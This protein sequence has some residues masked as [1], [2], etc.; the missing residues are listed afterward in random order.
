MFLPIGSVLF[1]WLLSILGLSSE[2]TKFFTTR[3]V[4]NEFKDVNRMVRA[5]KENII[6]RARLRL[7]VKKFM[8]NP[9]GAFI[10][11]PYLVLFISVP[12]ALI[13]DFIALASRINLSML[14]SPGA[15]FSVVHPGLPSVQTIASFDGIAV[16][17]LF[18]VV[19]PFT[20]F[21]ELRMHKIKKLDSTIP[22]FLKR[23][24]GV[25]ESGLTL[26]QAVKSLLR[27]NLGVLN[28]EVKKMVR[29]MEWG[30]DIKDALVRFE[31]RVSTPSISRTVTLITEASESSG[32]IKETLEIAS[33]DAGSAQT[34]QEE[35]STNML[36]YVLIVYIS[37]FV[38][39][40]IIY[41]LVV[42]FMPALPG[43]S[44]D[45]SMQSMSTM[46]ISF[47]GV[48]TGTLKTLFYHAVLIEGFF[49]GII[50]GMM[51][52]GNMFSGLKHALIMVLIGVVVFAVL[53]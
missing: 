30:A 43:V 47:N 34:L 17:T 42:V 36:L 33:A 13:I 7:S 11:R 48:D 22:E 18:I 3:R 35:R 1:L 2:H 23:L 45:T 15:F 24:A 32:D 27:S 39:L 9:F 46:G 12:V 40:Y 10:Q 25:N 49:S 4:L 14:S 37:F 19:L 50:A 26:A 38:F 16:L 28:V 6:Q 20:I 29:D 41:T 5:P 53:I 52:A 44:A 51:G 8:E 21:W 31:H